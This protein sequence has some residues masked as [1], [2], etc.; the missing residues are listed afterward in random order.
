MTMTTM[1]IDDDFK[2]SPVISLCLSLKKG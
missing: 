2:L 1:M